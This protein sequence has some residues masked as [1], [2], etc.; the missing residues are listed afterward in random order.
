[1]V[2]EGFLAG[3]FSLLGVI[4]NVSGFDNVEGF[5][6]GSVAITSAS[7]TSPAAAL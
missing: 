3:V 4:E 7:A 5:V 2:I 6:E 1:M